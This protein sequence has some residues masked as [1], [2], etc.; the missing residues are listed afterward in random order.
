MAFGKVKRRR[1][2]KRIISRKFVK[3][4]KNYVGRVLKGS[5][6][7]NMPLPQRL[8]TKFTAMVNGVCAAA[9]TAQRL[10]NIR[11]NG[12]VGPFNVTPTGT[13]I[14]LEGP[15]IPLANIDAA[16]FLSLCNGSMYTQYRVFG[17]SIALQFQPEAFNDIVYVSV[18]PS[19]TVN[20]PLNYSLA[21]SEP[22]TKSRTFAEA[23]SS[24]NTWLKN[25][26][27]VSKL[28]GVT[29]RAVQDDISTSYNAVFNNNPLDEMFWVINWCQTDNIPPAQPCAYTI[30]V[31]YYVELFAIANASLSQ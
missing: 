17:S 23:A 13:G 24:S 4:S 27:T 2:F 8:K 1:R 9:G 18:T 7:L 21:I 12:L 14:A 25:Y 15:F 29:P 10:Y 5:S 6:G 19:T 31:T 20:L 26:M 28:I 22:Y 30:K 16:G 3:K 11:M